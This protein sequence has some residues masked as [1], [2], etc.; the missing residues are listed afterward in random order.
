MSSPTTAQVPPH[1]GR[2]TFEDTWSEDYSNNHKFQKDEIDKKKVLG[3]I[4]IISI[5]LLGLSSLYF[6]SKILKD[7]VK[8]FFSSNSSITEQ[9][10]VP[11]TTYHP[12]EE[13]ENT[14]SPYD[15]DN[16]ILDFLNENDTKLVNKNL[17]INKHNINEVVK[18]IFKENPNDI[19]LPYQNREQEYSNLLFEQN[20]ESFEIK[21]SYT[22]DTILI[23]SLNRIPK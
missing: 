17:E 4:A 7:I 23:S 19:G 21:S 18:I 16:T 14:T 9:V 1:Q 20:R 6:G 22:N 2:K 15:N 13:E 5:I 8:S 10:Y 11:N 3:C 12:T